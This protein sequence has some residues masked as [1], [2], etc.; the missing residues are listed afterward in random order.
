ME[1][2]STASNTTVSSSAQTSHG[3]EQ[4]AKASTKASHE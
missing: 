4:L 3:S 1:A 2:E